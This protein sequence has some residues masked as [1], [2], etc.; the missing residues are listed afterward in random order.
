MDPPEQRPS[1]EGS[2]DAR[3]GRREASPRIFADLNMNNDRAQAM[4][5][6]LV[7]QGSAKFYL[8]VEL[9]TETTRTR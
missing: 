3:G 1:T 8:L 2:R 9:E 6:S 5:R 4:G 7:F